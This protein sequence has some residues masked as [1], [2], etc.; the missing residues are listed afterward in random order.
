MSMLQNI[1]FLRQLPH[2]MLDSV[3]KIDTYH[4]GMLHCGILAVRCRNAAENG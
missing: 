1:C 3:R 2:K 4:Q